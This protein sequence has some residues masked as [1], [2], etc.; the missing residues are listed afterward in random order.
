MHLLVAT[1]EAGLM[2]WVLPGRFGTT[3]WIRECYPFYCALA[4]V[5][6][7]ITLAFDFD[8]TVLHLP[9]ATSDSSCAYYNPAALVVAFNRVVY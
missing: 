1:V 8:G 7:A 2:A 3:S 9:L 4:L 6:V 5:G